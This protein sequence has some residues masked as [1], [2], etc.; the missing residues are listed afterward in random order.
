MAVGARLSKWLRPLV[1][2]GQNGLTRTGAAITTSSA[3]TMIAFWIAEIIRDRPAHP[4][5]G[6]LLFLILPGFFVLGLVLM[7]IGVWWRRREL[8]R[9]GALPS[10][11]PAV[12]LRLSDVRR[13]LAVIAV[14]TVANLAI[15]STASYKGCLLYTSDAA[16]E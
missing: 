8:R 4:Y 2:L 15:L 6:I 10:E 5:E 16:D 13:G 14:L 12:S 1:H 3:L 9:S 7:P 11:F